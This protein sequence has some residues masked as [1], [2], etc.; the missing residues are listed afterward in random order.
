MAKRS[1]KKAGIASSGGKARAKSLSA[2]RR[3]EIA[4]QAVEARWEK[5]GKS[6]TPRAVYGSSDKPLR[7]G[8]I[9]LP[10]YVLE[11]DTRVFSQRGLQEG[12]SL[13]VWGGASRM[14]K[15][16]A[17]ITANT[18]KHSDLTARVKN[19]IKFIPPHGGQIAHGYE[20]TVLAD[21]CDAILEARK[22]ERLSPRLASVA[23][24]CEILVRAFAKVGIIALVDEATGF[25]YERQKNSL[26]E[27]LEEFLS[28]E[29]RRWV[30]TFPATYFKELCRLKNVSYR[31]DMRLPQYFGHLTN[32]IVYKRLAPGVL[33]KLRGLNDVVDSGSRK[34]KHFQWLSQ[35]VGH[36]KLLQHLGAVVAMMKLSANWDTFKSHLDKVAPIHEELPL[37]DKASGS[38]VSSVA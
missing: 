35:D 12:L 36:P 17:S 14:I 32:D 6:P 1:E 18:G 3:S 16:M 38:E 4:R 5:Q 30:K 23:E 13:G 15:F 37:F 7:I 34:S 8:D 25:Q 20:A 2:D 33:D 11:D 9:E 10:C 29:L 19:P 27:L 21:L 28:A 31:P 24:R 22:D 26:E